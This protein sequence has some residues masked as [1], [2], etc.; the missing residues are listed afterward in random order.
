MVSF[1]GIHLS[2][3][4]P[5]DI[6]YTPL[7]PPLAILL[8]LGLTLRSIEHRVYRPYTA[9]WSP[10]KLEIWLRAVHCTGK[11]ATTSAYYYYLNLTP[12]ASQPLYLVVAFYWSSLSLLTWDPD[13]KGSLH[14]MVL[15]HTYIA[16]LMQPCN[17]EPKHT[18]CV[19]PNTYN[20]SNILNRNPSNMML[21][22]I[23]YYPCGGV[24]GGDN[25]FFF[26]L[27]RKHNQQS[28]NLNNFLYALSITSS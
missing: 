21:T 12:W 26:L 15:Q 7:Q 16:V 19:Q 13:R 27:H 1:L 14:C 6:S 9:A 5:K 3:H 2:P 10:D 25:N 20:E 11:S 4:C 23:V 22:E 8:L 24:G 17:C 28:L 18:V